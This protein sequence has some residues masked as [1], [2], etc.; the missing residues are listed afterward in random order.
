MEVKWVARQFLVD[1][2][3]HQIAVIKLLMWHVIERALDER[4]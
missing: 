3:E 2:E 4:Y 1:F